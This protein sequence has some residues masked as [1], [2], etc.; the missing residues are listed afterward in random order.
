M[1]TDPHTDV[2]DRLIRVEKHF[3][4]R[5]QWVVEDLSK[6]LLQHSLGQRD[7]CSP[8]VCMPAWMCVRIC[9]CIR[10]VCYGNLSREKSKWFHQLWFIARSLQTAVL[11][12]FICM[13]FYINIILYGSSLVNSH[14]ILSELFPLRCRTGPPL[15]LKVKYCIMH[16]IWCNKK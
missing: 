6:W 1:K 3:L 13:R 5:A 10:Y 9:M 14:G 8:C 2:T 15:H 4:C 11:W 16:R 12:L 7:L